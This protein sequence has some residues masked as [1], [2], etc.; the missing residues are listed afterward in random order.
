MPFYKN[1]TPEGVVKG[2]AFDNRT[3][4]LHC[5]CKNPGGSMEKRRYPASAFSLLPPDDLTY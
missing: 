3:N 5:H 2:V 4:S 1:S